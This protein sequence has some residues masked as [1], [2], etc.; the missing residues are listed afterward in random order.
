MA[1]KAN[2]F[3]ASCQKI[4]NDETIFKPIYNIKNTNGRGEEQRQTDRQTNRLRD[5]Q[6]DIKT[7]R[8]LDRQTN[9]T[10]SKRQIQ[11]VI[12]RKR[13]K[14]KKRSLLNIKIYKCLTLNQSQ[15]QKDLCTF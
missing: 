13:E 9:N 3:V 6:I 12:I 8:H 4:S 10:K 5:G 1:E 15:C 7:D 11:R 2:G 14:L